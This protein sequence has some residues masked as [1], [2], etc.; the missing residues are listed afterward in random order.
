MFISAFF[1]KSFVITKDKIIKESLFYLML[2]FFFFKILLWKYEAERKL[3][4]KGFQVKPCQKIFPNRQFF[5][6]LSPLLF[7]MCLYS[8]RNLNT[9]YKRTSQNF[10]TLINFQEKLTETCWNK[11]FFSTG[12]FDKNTLGVSFFFFLF[13]FY[14]F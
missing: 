5:L 4:E 1:S 14:A 12:L 13:Y 8:Y 7:F 3:P 11:G 6:L 2:R 9:K 10:I